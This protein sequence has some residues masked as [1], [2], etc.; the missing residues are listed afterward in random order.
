MKCNLVTFLVD[1]SNINTKLNST[2]ATLLEHVNCLIFK[3]NFQKIGLI[4]LWV[5]LCFKVGDNGESV[6]F[7]DATPGRVQNPVHFEVI[8]LFDDSFECIETQKDKTLFSL[9]L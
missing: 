9:T 6:F 2:V 7:S 1:S 8:T 3:V 5:I 4:Y